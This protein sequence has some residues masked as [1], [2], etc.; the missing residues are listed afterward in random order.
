M[1]IHFDCTMCGKCCHGLKLPL[2]IAEARSWLRRGGAVELLC[3]ATPWPSEPPAEDIAAQLMRDRSFVGASGALP[4]RIAVT[5]VAAFDGPCPFLLP[6][7]RCGGYE[8][9]PAVCRI[10][11][12]ELN[13]LVA[14]DPARK[15]CPPEAW[16]DT[17]PVYVVDDHPVDPAVRNL[18]VQARAANERDVGAKATLCTAL[19]I[20]RAALANEGFVSHKPEAHDLVEALDRCP[21]VDEP[22]PISHAWRIVSNRAATR[23]ML[24]DAGAVSASEGRDDPAYLGFFPSG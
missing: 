10:Y 7:M 5:L 19:G 22:Y 18:I 11:P 2:S 15:S 24:E 8:D 16:A 20:D 17:Q 9:R 3:E 4:V 21:D 6:D 13:P 23:A 1:N 14:L 12:A